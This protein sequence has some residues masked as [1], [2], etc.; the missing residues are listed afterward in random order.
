MSDVDTGENDLSLTIT[1][2]DPTAGTLSGGGFTETGP[3]TGVYTSDGH[4]RRPG[5]HRTRQRHLHARPTTPAPRAP[6]TPTSPSRSTTRAAA[7]S[8]ACWRPPPSP[9]PGSTTT[10][11]AFVARSAHHQSSTTMPAPPVLFAGLTVSDVDTGENDLSLTITLTDPRGGNPLRRWLHRDRARHRDLHGHRADRNGPGRHRA[12]QRHLHAHQQHRPLRHFNTDISVTVNDQG[13]GGEQSV[14]APTTVTVTRVNDDPG[15]AGSLTTTSLNDNAGATALFAGPHGER[16]RCRRERSLAHHHPH[17]SHRRHAERR[18]L[19][20]DR[21]GHRYL[22]AHGADRRPRPTPRS[23]TSPS[24][25]PTTPA[26]RAPSTPISPSP[27]TIRAAAASRAC[28]R[29]TTVTITRVNDDPSG[30]GSLTTTS[31]QRQRGCDEPL[32]AGLTVGDVDTGENDLSLTITLTDPT[33]GTLSGGG[34]TETGPEHRRLHLYGHDR[35]PRPTRH[36]TTSPSRPPT[37]VVPRAP[38]TPTSRSPS[39]TR[40]AVASRAC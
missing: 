29:P 35:R 11:Q 6:S 14:L 18:R 36:S 38:S 4:D 21:T 1:L 27:S 33:A 17:R 25:R 37:T 12:G 28:W 2:T 5:Q 7:V 10:Q 40:A 13:G 31:H 32:F 24:P 20:R 39:T 30:A 8:R 23:T 15:G 16:R 3:G 26:P 9:S 22:H 34:F 19:H